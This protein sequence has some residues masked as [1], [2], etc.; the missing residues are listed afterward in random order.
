VGA[1]ASIAAMA[2]LGDVEHVRSSA[3]LNADE[4]QE[5]CNQANARMHRTIDSHANFVML[6]TAGPAK[7]VVEHF[8][9]NHVL[10]GGSIPGFPKHV[11]VSIGSA[12]DM[13]EFWRVWD[14]MPPRMTM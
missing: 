3:R 5:F 14:L 7:A 1:L 6:D 12:G 13:R 11:R 2:A 4:R 9:A 10:I 8:Q